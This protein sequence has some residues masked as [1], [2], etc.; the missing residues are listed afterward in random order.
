MTAP[1]IATSVKGNRV[2][3]AARRRVR[4]LSDATVERT[5]SWRLTPDFL[6]V[7]AQRCGTTSLFKTLAQHPS[8][9][10]PFL[11]KGVHYFDTSY[12]RGPG[13]YRGHFP[14]HA[15]SR[16]RRRGRRVLTGE[17]SPYYLFHPWAAQRI[18][19]DLPGVRLLVLLRDPVE[20]AY[21]AHAHET[22]KGFE[23]LPFEEALEAEPRRLAGELDR[24]LADPGYQSDAHQHNA[25][26]TRGQYVDQLV[27]LE[28]AVG[29]DRILVLDSGDFFSDPE[30]VFGRVLAFLDLPAESRIVFERHNAR[31]RAPMSDSLR[32]RLEEHFAPFDERLGQWWGQEP[33]WRR[34]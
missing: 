2:A 33:S 8:V 21:S 7:G 15:S 22:A 13:W 27:A 30:P 23:S 25:Y 11:R 20:R 3:R 18:A 10:R 12:D 16:A 28:R 24:M 34:T 5:A 29:R 19:R 4:S 9:A 14:I 31:G 32:R 26:L 1:G 17:S 6:I